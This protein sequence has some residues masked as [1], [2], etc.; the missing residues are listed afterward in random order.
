MTLL[1]AASTN[2]IWAVISESTI[3]RNAVLPDITAAASGS[4]SNSGSNSH[5]TNSRLSRTSAA[6]ATA[7]AAAGKLRA[8]TAAA[9]SAPVYES[10]GM[11]AACSQ[12]VQMVEDIIDKW[13]HTVPALT[14]SEIQRNK[15]ADQ[16]RTLFYIIVELLCLHCK[17][18]CHP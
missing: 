18:H 7:A 9:A 16:V 1:A 8:A 13:P 11:T 2:E 14:V 4:S 6:A 15:P 5:H 3:Y 12:V 17:Q 10:G